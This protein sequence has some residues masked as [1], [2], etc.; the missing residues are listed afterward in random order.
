VRGT[1]SGALKRGTIKEKG[2]IWNANAE[3]G[4]SQSSKEFLYGQKGVGGGR[5]QAR[6]R[7]LEIRK[8][9]D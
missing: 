5:Y 7:K 3:K 6:K 9:I 8:R 2:N 1:K 4:R